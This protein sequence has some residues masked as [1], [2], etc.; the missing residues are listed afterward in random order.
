MRQKL[1]LI[2]L[3][4]MC[5]A[6]A[7]FNCSMQVAGGDG[8]E[9]TNGITATVVK[10]DNTP[11]ANIM[12]R[13]IDSENW[14]DKSANSISVV[15]DSVLTDEKGNFRFN[16]IAAQHYNLILCGEGESAI[17][18]ALF[19]FNDSILPLGTIMT[20]PYAVIKGTVTADTGNVTQV[21]LEGTHFKGLVSVMGDF[22]LPSV[23][24]GDFTLF[25]LIESGTATDL[26]Y[27]GGVSLQPGDT[28]A[29]FG[30]TAIFDGILLDNFDDKDSLS[31]LHWI[32][33]GSYWYAY[34]DAGMGGNSIIEPATILSDFKTA[35]FEAGAYKGTSVH[36]TFIM[37][38][39]LSGPHCSIACKLLPDTGDYVDLTDMTK[40]TF[41]ARGRDSIRVNFA[42]KAVKKYP[43]EYSGGDLGVTLVC[44]A[45]WEK[46]TV[47]IN[48]IAPPEG[49]Q[50]AL[51]SLTWEE[52]RDSVYA[53][54]FGSW[55]HYGDTVDLYLDEIAVHGVD[56]G[57]FSLTK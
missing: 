31:Q 51:D 5:I 41:Y 39:A 40:L 18:Q 23:A 46:F 14:F 45:D 26:T 33:P 2:Q 44:P 56:V 24:A 28:A 55:A 36:A 12:V 22:G 32:T 16:T 52:A 9:T 4:I 47:D 10:S 37:G 19:V 50:Q 57:H 48:Q 25:A 38:D 6:V 1:V 13:L 43:P 21:L 34:T 3:F 11:A 53:I 54:I 20:Q 17:R 29:T 42:S 49:S 35:F 15:I 8:S 30:L 7:L 27:A